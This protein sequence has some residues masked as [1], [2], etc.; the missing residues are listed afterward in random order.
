MTIE[1]MIQRK[2][3]LG[4]TYEQIASLSGIPIGTVQKVLGGT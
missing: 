1:Q 2:N 3:E 4:L